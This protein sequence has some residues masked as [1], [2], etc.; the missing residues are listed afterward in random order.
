MSFFT[1]LVNYAINV[2]QFPFV[3]ISIIVLSQFSA[4]F[5]ICILI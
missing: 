3:T 1:F 2:F 5:A 4:N